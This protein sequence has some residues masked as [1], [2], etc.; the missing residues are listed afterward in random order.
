MQKFDQEFLT[1]Q[2]LISVR[3]IT[4]MMKHYGQKQAGKKSFVLLNPHH[5]SS[6]KEVRAGT[7]QGGKLEAGAD[8]EATEH[9]LLT[10]SSL[11]DQPALLE[12]P[13]PPAQGR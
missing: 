8:A 5:S 3:V 9:C 12:K 13:G 4:A 1:R 6:R 10:C 7:K 11:L 2:T